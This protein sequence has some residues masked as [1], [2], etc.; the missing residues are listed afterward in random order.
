M[1]EGDKRFNYRIGSPSL[2]SL[3]EIV[4][5]NSLQIYSWNVSSLHIF[6]LFSHS[7]EMDS[8]PNVF[9]WIRFWQLFFFFFFY[10]STL[11]LV[12]FEKKNAPIIFRAKL[13]CLWVESAVILHNWICFL[14]ALLVL[15]ANLFSLFFLFSPVCFLPPSPSFFFLHSTYLLRVYSD[16]KT[17]EDIRHTNNTSC[18]RQIL[19]IIYILTC[20]I[21]TTT[22]QSQ[23]YYHSYLKVKT[24][25][26]K[27]LSK[28]AL[29]RKKQSPKPFLIKISISK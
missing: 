11:L 14:L 15:S 22:I 18:K 12:P 24:F 25:K 2:R 1:R 26:H 19:C 10:K 13:L 17:G 6:S 21:Y 20:S 29:L 4:W 23:W 3:C 7:R 5:N 8:F 16:P 27:A 9:I 28:F